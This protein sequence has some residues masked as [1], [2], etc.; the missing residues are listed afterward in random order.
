[1]EEM[2][3]ARE[4][5]TMKLGA[6]ELEVERLNARVD[7]LCEEKADAEAQLVHLEMERDL[8]KVCLQEVELNR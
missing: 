5:L 7:T 4:D 2:E 8:F 3:A 1:M 6:T